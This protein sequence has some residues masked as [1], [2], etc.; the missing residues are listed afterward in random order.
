[1]SIPHILG[2]HHVTA[3]A[4]QP[5]QNL[6]FYVGVLGLRLVKRTV[7]FDAPDT[8]HF[9]YGDQTGQPGSIMT[10]FPFRGMGPGRIGASQ[11]ATTAFSIPRAALDFWQQRLARFGVTVTGP[12][13]RWETTVLRLHDWDG[14]SLELV[15]TDDE[16]RPGYV[17][18]D[19]PAAHSI[20]G[21]HGVT[22]LVRRPEPTV[23]V[24]TGLLNH[25]VVAES[26]DRIRLTV[27]GQPGSWVEVQH[28][29]QAQPGLQGAGTVHHVAF[30]T[31]DDDSQ[32][33]LLATLQERGM[34]PSPVMD[35]QYFHSVYFREPNGILFEIATDPPGFLLDESEAELGRGLKLAPWQEPQRREIEG[36]LAEI[37]LDRAIRLAPS[38]VPAA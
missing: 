15:A 9:Y 5:Q 14:L 20:R 27:N 2:L 33:K 37:D 35:R 29:P 32:A 8:Y 28:D 17:Q 34:V 23:E 38:Q 13:E 6:D 1:M 7:N 12:F 24:L 36:L 31:T 30:R 4:G 3:L 10:F 19:I 25:R 11:L 18:G 21:F 22:L 16:Q 26:S